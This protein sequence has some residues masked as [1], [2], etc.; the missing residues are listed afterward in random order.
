MLSNENYEKTVTFAAFQTMTNAVE[1][2]NLQQAV[3]ARNQQLEAM[4]K[5]IKA[6]E[7]NLKARAEEIAKLQAECVARRV[8]GYWVGKDYDPSVTFDQPNAAPAP[9]AVTTEGG[10]AD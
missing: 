4:A 7:E 10:A 2:A 9:E 6:N 1:I 5:T 8:N 3:Q